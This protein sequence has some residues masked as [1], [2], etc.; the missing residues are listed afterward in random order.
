MRLKELFEAYKTNITNKKFNGAFV[1]SRD[2]ANKPNSGA[3]STVAQDKKD[4][5]MVRKW[6]H[7]PMTGEENKERIISDRTDED[8]IDDGF[9]Q[10]A[11]WLAKSDIHN[12]CFPRIY[13]IN[14]KEDKYGNYIFDY[15]VEKLLEPDELSV[16]E[17]ESI[18]DH[19]FSISEPVKQWH[20]ERGSRTMAKLFSDAINQTISG[21]SNG[22]IKDEALIE[23]LSYLKKFMKDND[24]VMYD[25]HSGNIMYRRTSHG[26]QLVLNDPVA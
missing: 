11:I 21:S 4:P 5:H 16:E 15:K 25:L 19:Y 24:D 7:G 20:M 17:M 12:P 23:A 18:C 13:D 26:L 6:N 22:L 9:K 14:R 3:Y 1:Q 2:S 8:I 10:F